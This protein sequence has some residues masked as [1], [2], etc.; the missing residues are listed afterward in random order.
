MLV[1][2]ESIE[3]IQPEIKRL[4]HEFEDI[5][6]MPIG[7]P[8]MRQIDHIIQLKKG[9][10]PINVRPYRY[11]HAQKKRDQKIGERDAGFRY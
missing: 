6:V 8:Q 4:Q 3:E 2:M 5:F 10:D 7:C 9:T 11:P 1:A